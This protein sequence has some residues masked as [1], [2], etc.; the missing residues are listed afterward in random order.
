M[1]GKGKDYDEG[2]VDPAMVFTD[3]SSSEL[4]ALQEANEVLNVGKDAS[5]DESDEDSSRDKESKSQS[6]DSESEEEYVVSEY[7]SESSYSGVSG[8]PSEVKDEHIVEEKQESVRNEGCIENLENAKEKDIRKD[9]LGSSRTSS[10]RSESE[11]EENAQNVS[12]KDIRENGDT[13]GNRKRK[14]IRDIRDDNELDSSAKEAMQKE[15]ERQL[16][17]K[18][19]I[20]TA[21]REIMHTQPK[22]DISQVDVEDDNDEGVKRICVENEN[23]VQS[24][25]VQGS[26]KGRECD[27]EKKLSSDAEII[28]LSESDDEGD[29]TSSKPFLV[30]DEDEHKSSRLRIPSSSGHVV[31]NVYYRSTGRSLGNENSELAEGT[32]SYES[33]GALISIPDSNFDLPEDSFGLDEKNLLTDTPHIDDRLNI[34]DE[35]GRVLVNV[36]HPDHEKPVYLRNSLACAVKPHQI[37]GIRF[38]FDNIIESVDNYE[39]DGGFGCILAH[40]MGLGKT[41]QTIALID[42]FLSNTPGRTALICAPVNT[43]L[44]WEAEFKKWLKKDCM[45]LFC[46][47]DKVKLFKERASIVKKWLKKGGVMIIGY[48]MFSKLS[49]SVYTLLAPGPELIICDE[50]HKIKNNNTRMANSL[51]QVLTKRRVCLTGYP[52]AE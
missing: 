21:K 7:D 27:K 23:S 9:L 39:P 10:E 1:S 50:G 15:K 46:I 34:P 26:G 2:G 24:F 36:G 28:V 6:S 32:D 16:R 8:S 25:V 30:D 22:R 41:I 29:G 38:M 5:A 37:G 47:T 33:G 45:R 42:L 18:Q 11:D 17:A 12:G 20:E 4:G 49:S 40:S 43:L 13:F 52:F 51:K 35:Q 31:K 44:N 19:R 3:E 48:E 14:E